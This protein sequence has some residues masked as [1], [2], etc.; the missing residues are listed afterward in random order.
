VILVTLVFV[1][2]SGAFAVEAV[3]VVDARDATDGRKLSDLRCALAQPQ[4]PEPYA[5]FDGDRYSGE[6]TPRAGDHLYVYHRGHDLARVELRDSRTVQVRLQPAGLSCEVVITGEGVDELLARR[7]LRMGHV[8]KTTR[9]R[10]EGMVR[11]S[12]ER[13]PTAPRLTV[14][15]GRGMHLSTLCEADAGLVW[16]VVWRARPDDKVVLHYE[17]GRRLSVRRGPA[18]RRPA[19]FVECLPDLLWKP[20]ATPKQIDAWRWHLNGPGWLRDPFLKSS[21]SVHLLPEIPFHLFVQLGEERLYR[22]VAPGAD[23]IDLRDPFGSRPVR[24]RP[25]LDG[26][27]VRAG[28]ILAPGRLDLY[29][30]AA[31]AS[32]RSRA[33][34]FCFEVSA[35]GEWPEVFLPGSVWLTAWHPEEGLAHFEWSPDGTTEGAPYRG[36]VSF[37]APDGWTATGYVSLYPVWRGAGGV[38]TTPPDQ[39]LR[40]RF[41]GG[42]GVAFRGVAPGR[43]AAD[44]RVCLR[45]EESGAEREVGRITEFDVNEDRLVVE[46]PL[47]R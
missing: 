27:P 29:S 23:E 17:R 43:Y 37:T 13:N 24:E 35:D 46:V 31:I 41:E 3:L 28:T 47:T 21:E 42:R 2:A 30:I 14:K 22:Y 6:R 32:L 15:W 33:E 8:L 9:Q 18:Q 12:F 40:R 11:D 19:S 45:H 16:P 1:L 38:R 10:R 4:Q 44:I 20:G 39:N 26:K 25:C 36:L 34:G 5:W 7:G